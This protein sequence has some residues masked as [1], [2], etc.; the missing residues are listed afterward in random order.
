[1][2]DITL[3]H[4]GDIHYEGI[5]KDDYS[6]ILNKDMSFPPYLAR[7]ISPKGSYPTIVRSLSKEINNSTLVI[8]ISGDLCVKSNMQDYESCLNFLKNKI[9][10]KRFFDNESS[11]KIFIVP[12]NHDLDRKKV[13]QESPYSKFETINEYHKK[14]EFPLIPIDKPLQAK[15]KEN[16]SK[17]YIHLF[18]VNS[19]IGCGEKR[20]YRS[21]IIKVISELENKK[22]TYNNLVNKGSS[23]LDLC[24]DEIDTPIILEENIDAILSDIKNNSDS[25]YLPIILAHHNLLPQKTLKVAMYT[26]LMNNGYVR[27]K[28]LSLNKPIIYLHGHIHDDPIEIIQSPFYEEARIICISAP[29]LCPN[30]VDPEANKFGFNKLKIIFGSNSVPIGCKITFF[31]L[32]LDEMEE[33]ETII[34]FIDP[35]RALALATNEEKFILKVI[36]HGNSIYISDLMHELESKKHKSI[37]IEELGT[38]IDR[39][40][41]LGLVVYENGRT[42]NIETRRVRGI[43]S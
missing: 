26:D 32:K 23:L 19:C 16:D 20:Y 41:I 24:F 5:K 28:L 2:K 12:G 39:L 31:R 13:S 3:L 38:L 9:I 8:L 43:Y 18:A 14:L 7:D 21:E 10:D 35:A 17:G 37:S 34:P 30:A 36:N 42:K 6:R 29:L 27:Q 25:F 15:I 4:I 22:S 33:E 40:S 1:M 11:K